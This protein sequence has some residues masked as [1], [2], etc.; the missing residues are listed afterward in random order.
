MKKGFILALSV[1]FMTLILFLVAG[2]LTV[3]DNF[4]RSVTNEILL[5]NTNNTLYQIEEYII[6]GDTTSQDF[7]AVCGDNF[8]V[9][10]TNKPDNGQNYT[11]YRVTYKGELRLIMVVDNSRNVISRR[12]YN[13]D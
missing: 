3:S 9:K 10:W 1:S 4:T 8:E 13:Y 7:L 6:S 11:E 2:V 12:Y 5:F